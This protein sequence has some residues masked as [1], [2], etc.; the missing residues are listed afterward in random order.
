MVW[1]MVFF[2]WVFRSNLLIPIA[3]TKNHEVTVGIAGIGSWGGGGL[4]S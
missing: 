2:W 4:V 3:F 1:L